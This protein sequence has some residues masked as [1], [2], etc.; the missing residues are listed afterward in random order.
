MKKNKIILAIVLNFLFVNLL[1]AQDFTA[2]TTINVVPKSGF[3]KINITPQLSSHLK[4]DFS[5]FRIYDNKGEQVQYVLDRKNTF[6]NGLN[7]IEFPIISNVVNEKKNTILIIENKNYPNNVSQISLLLQNSSVSRNA[8]ISGNNDNAG[9]F[10]IANSINI[11]Q[12]NETIESYY[13]NKISIAKSNYK[14]FKIEIDNK[15]EDPYNILKAGI[16]VENNN[17]VVTVYNQNPTLKFIQKDSSDKKTYINVSN[18]NSFLV[19]KIS[20][21]FS[22]PKFYNRTLEINYKRQNNIASSQSKT[23][24]SNSLNVLEINVGKEKSF[25]LVIDNNDNPPLKLDSLITYQI[26]HH[27]IAYLEQGKQ[28]Q[29]LAEN[30]LAQKPNYDLEKFNDII[31]A[32]I[33]SIG[34]GEIKTID[35]TK[36]VEKQKNSYWLWI[37]IATAILV[38]GLLTKS[39]LADMKKKNL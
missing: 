15:K 1:F 24:K 9:W 21:F 35:K 3:Y 32:I 31:P 13:V 4:F 5:D 36:P 12:E 14:Y 23:I 30:N 10:I 38:M 39:L 29:I 11:S 37:A 16:N 26:E 22:G 19:N 2:S 7:F 33:D 25:Q 27:V 8:K 18:E 6:I 28:Y 34:F 20:T 17:K